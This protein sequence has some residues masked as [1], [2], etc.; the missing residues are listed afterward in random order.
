MTPSSRQR[1]VNAAVAKVRKLSQNCHKPGPAS[2]SAFEDLANVL[3]CLTC[4]HQQGS[5]HLTKS[6]KTEQRT[7]TLYGGLRPDESAARLS[8]DFYLK[9]V[10]SLFLGAD[11]YLRVGISQ[12]QYQKDPEGDDWIFRFDYERDPGEKRYPGAHL[13]VNGKLKASDSLP[14]KKLLEHVHFPVVRPSLE[15]TLRLLME[16]FDVTSVNDSSIWRPAFAEAERIFMEHVHQ[17]SPGLPA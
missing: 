7:A 15:T 13:H 12:F 14:R 11:G 4:G 3:L 17:P 10:V 6:R 2:F 16:Q 8:N 5:V 9:I 1:D